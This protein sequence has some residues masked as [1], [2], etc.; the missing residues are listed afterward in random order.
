MIAGQTAQI[1]DFTG[2][3]WPTIRRSVSG[4][5]LLCDGSAISRSTYAALFAYLCPNSTVTITIASP[6]V[7]TWNSHPLVNGDKIMLST[8]GALPTG[9]SAGVVYFVVGV[10]TNTFKLA[11]T[12]GGADINTSGSQSGTH[13]ATCVT[14]GEGD[15]STTFNLPDYRGRKLVGAGANT[16]TLNFASADV[17]TGTDEITVPQNTSLYPGTKVRLT[18]TG[19]LPTGLALATDY[20]VIRISSTVIKLASSRNNALGASGSGATGTV[21]AI[22]ITGA[23]SGTHTITIQ[24]LTTRIVGEKGGEE[25]HSLSIEEMPSHVHTGGVSGADANDASLNSN[26]INIPTGATGGSTP[27]NIMNPYGVVNFFIHT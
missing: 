11:L 1:S 6:G 5:W 9:L 7:L 20:Y 18:T 14:H 17:N 23:G 25:T 16:F 22:D 15:G 24:D 19:T 8:T 2:F 12:Y 13:T 26:T 21:T 10:T 4:G 3:I 27:H